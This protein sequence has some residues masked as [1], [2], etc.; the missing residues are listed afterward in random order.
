[1]PIIR[2][3]MLEGRSAEAKAAL[4]RRL[5]QAAVE[6]LGVEPGRV[7]VLLHELPPEN[8]GVA[9]EPLSPPTPVKGD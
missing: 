1:M 6:T 7:R 9:G 8:W 3:E 4:M 2:V 5:T